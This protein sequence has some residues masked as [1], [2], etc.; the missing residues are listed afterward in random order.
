[1]RVNRQVGAVSA[2]F[3]VAAA[4][5]LPVAPASFASE[6]VAQRSGAANGQIAFTE[7]D[8]AQPLRAAAPQVWTASPDG[9][10][11][12]RQF[13]AIDEN[14]A[15][16]QWSP[17]GQ[18]LAFYRDNTLMV[19]RADGSEARVVAPGVGFIGGVTA[20]SP[21]GTR[22]AYAREGKPYHGQIWVVNADGS[23]AH[24]IHEG[25]G[26]AGPSWSPDGRSIAFAQKPPDDSTG[27]ASYRDLAVYLMDPDGANVRRITGDEGNPLA[28]FIEDYAPDWSPDG[29]R[30]AFVSARDVADPM[31][32]N[33]SR[34]DVY[35]MK[36]DG[37]D[38]VRYPEEG[39]EARP[40]WSPD[41]SALAYVA[42][43]APPFSAASNPIEVDIR[44]LTTS[45]THPVA[46]VQMNGA[47]DWGPVPGSMPMA[48]LVSTVAADLDLVA[49]GGAVR[50][51]ATIHNNGGSPASG[52]ALELRLPTGAQFDGATPG[53]AG[54][55][56]VRCDVGALGVGETRSFTVGTSAT[57]A[58]MLETSV[59]AISA[60]ADP[61][62]AN[63]R[64]VIPVTVCTELGGAGRDTLTGTKGDDVL[65]GD[66]G[67][68]TLRGGGGADVLLGGPGNDRLDG[69][70]GRDAA[71]Y[72]E[73][74][75]KVKASLAR[76]RATGEGRDR[77]KRVENLAGSR[78]ADR[79]SGS[80]K[81]NVVWGLGGRDRIDGLAGKDLVLA[82]GDDDRIAPGS[83]GD[84]VDGGVGLDV[85]DYRQSE[86]RVK[87]D[88]HGR[89]ASAEGAD[90]FGSIEGVIGSR[91]GD[92]LVG[93]IAGNRLV[94]GL[95]DDR[96]TAA[97]GNDKVS[98]GGGA[99]R[100]AGGDGDDR[101]SGGAG[102][103]R[104]EQ[105]F[106]RGR[107]S[108]CERH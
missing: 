45:A 25:W 76:G 14:N 64:S 26:A 50:Y 77:I 67:D 63:N 90:A 24:L 104:C 51:T 17:D 83:G 94:G 79:L 55:T 102:R 105:D 44:D 33:C 98:G 13:G 95:G 16:P 88:L 54:T 59:L 81:S 56:V 27:N 106:G 101:L 31:C 43:P 37:T 20:W 22:I 49:L 85:L 108:Q 80:D 35:T 96:I 28:A 36:P 29:S 15:Y 21:D 78:F 5:V 19:A 84:T 1:M 9:T 62:T 65:C 46:P 61:E 32:L 2:V 71:S 74:T 53:C 89:T 41:G 23:D 68:D 47:A 4:L 30:I 48:D 3:A 93:S 92:K 42:Q 52:A 72:A 69:G 40:V 97:G 86:R 38:V 100:L 6:Q 58:G 11:V 12:H 7:P 73:A 18:W 60:T 103:D 70:A 10:D 99:D 66:G 57:A 107:T 91:F 8:P 34:Y 82:G 39:D 75:S 87:V